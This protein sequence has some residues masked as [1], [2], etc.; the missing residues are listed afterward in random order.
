MVGGH[1]AG[2]HAVKRPPLPAPVSV[3]LPTP[4]SGP[5]PRRAFR[6][7]QFFGVGLTIGVL[8]GF[9]AGSIVSLWVGDETLEAVRDALDRLAGRRQRV[10]FELLL[11]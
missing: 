8:V 1:P 9:V 2:A 10:N 11:Q 3:P 6:S 4:V 5:S 7:G